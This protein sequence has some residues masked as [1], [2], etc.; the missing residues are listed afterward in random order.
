MAVTLELRI[1][2][3]ASRAGK[4]TGNHALLAEDAIDEGRLTHIGPSDDR[5]TCARIVRNTRIAFR[6]RPASGHQVN[7][8]RNPIAMRGGDGNDRGQTKALEVGIH[9]VAVQ[10]FGLVDRERGVDAAFT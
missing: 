8:A 6:G 1:H 10:A 9:D 5:D 3:V 2:A 4:V 7:Q